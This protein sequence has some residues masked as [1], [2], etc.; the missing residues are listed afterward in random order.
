MKTDKQIRDSLFHMFDAMFGDNRLNFD[1]PESVRDAYLE[2]FHNNSPRPSAKTLLYF[3]VDNLDS[4]KG[5][6]DWG[7]STDYD[8]HDQKWVQEMMR[9]FDCVVDIYSKNPGQAMDAA[10]FLVS[11]LRGDRWEYLTQDPDWFFGKE[12]VSEPH[13]IRVIENSTWDNRVHFTIKLNFRDEIR[14]AEDVAQ[15]RMPVDFPDMQNITPVK[16]NS[17]VQGS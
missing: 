15:V 16:V 17:M 13:P 9:Q 4:W 3:Y 14:L 7:R 1:F 8:P 10:T 5:A 6:R 11:M 12:S 2:A